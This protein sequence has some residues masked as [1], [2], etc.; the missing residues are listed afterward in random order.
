L[1]LLG[2]FIQATGM[3]LLQNASN[4][5]VTILG[6]IESAA[7]RISFMGVCNKMAGMIGILL[8]GQLLFSDT[9]AFSKTITSLQGAELAAQ[10]D[11]LSARLITPYVIMAIALFLLAGLVLKAKLPEVNPESDV[12]NESGNEKTSVFQYPYLLLGVVCIFTYVGVEVIA[13][14]SLGLY[15]QYH[16]FDLKTSSNFGVYSLIAFTVGYLL[17]AIIIPKIISQNAALRLCAVLSILFALGALF[18][19]GGVSIGFIVALSFAHSL[20]WP[21]IWPLAIEGLGKFTKVGSSLLIM[22]IVGGA[23][24]PLVYGAIADATNRQTAYWMLMPCYAY[25]LYY[26]MS[27]YKVGRAKPQLKGAAV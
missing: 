27:G 10:L 3:T 13:I 6:P 7:K 8:L 16:G 11:A 15:G 24:L 19:E 21:S 1:F 25:I 12:V 9:E 22:G 26:A 23:L 4:P 18:T 14:D 2:L 5:Y 20:M 17:G